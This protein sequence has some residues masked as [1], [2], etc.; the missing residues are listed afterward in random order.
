MPEQSHLTLDHT[1]NANIA[2]NDVSIST[3]IFRE[4]TEEKVYKKKKG[5]E[6]D[7]DDISI[8]TMMC[9]EEQEA[10]QASNG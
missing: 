7:S 9:R 2:S 8:R 10:Q 1:K 3:V 6:K 5:R 4:V